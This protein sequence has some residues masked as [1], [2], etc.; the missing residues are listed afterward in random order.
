MAN[1]AEQPAYFKKR[2]KDRP[3]KP[4]PPVELQAYSVD[5]TVVGR[6]PSLEVAAAVYDS[7]GTMLN[8]DVEEAS[9]SGSSTRAGDGSYFRIQQRIDVP[10]KAKTMRFAVRDATTD[11]VGAMEISL[12][13][14]TEPSQASLPGDTAAET[15]SKS[16]Q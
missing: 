3:A 4:L 11:R 14:K 6:Q 2:K 1:L 8:G 16:N 15:P 7:E 13:L 9:S 12:P 10:A 5:Y